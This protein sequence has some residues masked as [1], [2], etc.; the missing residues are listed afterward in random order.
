MIGVVLA[1]GRGLRLREDVDM[2]EIGPKTLLSIDG[3]TLL[4]R[5]VADLANFDAERVNVVVGHRAD[6]V[7]KE[8][9]SLESKYGIEIRLLNNR[10]YASTNT[11][12][13]LQ[14]GI[15]D[16]KEDA[17]I[18]NGDV[19]Y[20]Y[21][22]LCRLIDSSGTAISIDNNKTLT[23]ES[24][25][26]TIRDGRIERMGKDIPIEAASGEFIGL[27]KIIKEDL[28]DAR[29]FLKELIA[30]DRNSYYDHIYRSLSQKGGVAYSY[31][32]GLRWTEIDDIDD[33]RYAES[34]ASFCA[35]EH[36]N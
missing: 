33:L 8:C 20:E 11:A 28:S 14:L 27:S 26:L 5:M 7:Q 29:A 34:I 36:M 15:K 30:E 17:V 18:F 1:A 3:H 12:C 6:L 21:A 13:S 2:E 19:L 9:F 25:K 10:D 23:G 31:T 22:I 32:D 16:V 24:F 35:R 4:E